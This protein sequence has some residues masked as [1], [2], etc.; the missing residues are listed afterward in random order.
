MFE[1]TGSKI[2]IVLSLTVMI[3]VGVFFVVSSDNR[4]EVTEEINTIT[5]LN[6]DSY[7]FDMY[8]YSADSSKLYT[9]SYFYNKIYLDNNEVKYDEFSFDTET[10]FYLKSLSN[11]PTDINNVKITYDPIT[12]DEFNFLLQN[13]TLLKVNIWVDK[14][15]VCDK[16]LLYANNEIALD[17]EGF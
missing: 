3:I 11:T 4:E 13:Y 15:G 9:S 7:D 1:S 10:I 16:V 2:L 14:S 12:F 17:L 5:G 8:I 6:V